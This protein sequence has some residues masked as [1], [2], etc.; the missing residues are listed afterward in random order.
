MLAAD[1][2]DDEQPPTTLKW[3]E[4]EEGKLVERCDN[5]AVAD[6]DGDDDGD[7]D[8]GDEGEA[9]TAVAAPVG[10]G[11]VSDDECSESCDIGC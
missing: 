8:E 4:D 6:V 10:T 1:I 11:T 9:T 5:E 3:C 2:G 7:V